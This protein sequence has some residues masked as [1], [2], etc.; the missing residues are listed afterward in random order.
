MTGCDTLIVGQGIAGTVLA[1]ELLGRGERVV[2]ADF[3]EPLPGSAS[4]VAAG[5]MTPV[6]GRRLVRSD[7]W[8]TAWPLAVALYRRAE[9]V[10]GVPLL[11]ERPMLRLFA[12]PDEVSRYAEREGGPFAGWTRDPAP[13]IDGGELVAPLGGFEMPTAGVLDAR[14]FVEA[15]RGHFRRLGALA[16]VTTDVTESMRPDADG[17]SVPALGIRAGRVVLCLGIGGA[18][19]R[20]FPGVPFAPDRGEVLHLDMPDL[21]ETR[22]IHKGVWL[23]PDGH[24]R[25]RL[26]GTHQ[27]SALTD[28]PSDEARA[29]L[30][31]AL[32]SLTPRPARVLAQSAGVRPA[33]RDARPVIGP[34]PEFPRVWLLNGL[35]GK[36]ALLAPLAARSLAEGDVPAAW[37]WPRD[38]GRR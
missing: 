7:I 17:V 8:P 32:P 30:L 5:L 33:T 27:W 24:G 3:A 10:L 14:R 15:S 6:T 35:G 9:G 2:V 22:V 21:C 37:R 31:A 23:V 29:E 13:P 19:C 38:R 25:A 4:R 12:S 20:W 11:A 28:P 26:G 16:E 1:W 34:H 36:G 18:G